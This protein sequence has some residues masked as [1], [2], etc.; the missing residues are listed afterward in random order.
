M[1]FKTTLF[2]VF[3]FLG[4]SIFKMV[5]FGFWVGFWFEVQVGRSL[6]GEN[7]KKIPTG[8]NVIWHDKKK[9]CGRP[10]GVL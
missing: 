4:S 8:A 6:F 3:F 5:I 9:P 1:I 7:K 10:Y 2:V